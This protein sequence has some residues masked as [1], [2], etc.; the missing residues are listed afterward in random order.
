MYLVYDQSQGSNPISTDLYFDKIVVQI[1]TATPFLLRNIDSVEVDSLTF[2]RS[3]W[4]LQNGYQ[5]GVN[6]FSGCLWQMLN[7]NGS[8]VIPNRLGRKHT[9]VLTLD[10]EN[11]MVNV[12]N[13]LLFNF[14]RLERM[15]VGPQLYWLGG[16]GQGATETIANLY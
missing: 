3:Q 14:Q 8:D 9:E 6:D 11:P 12:C 15:L 5:S 1:E 4:M 16:P 7:R 13:L 2:E 10:H